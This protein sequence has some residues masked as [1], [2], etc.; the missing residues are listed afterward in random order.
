MVKRKV[1]LL[2]RRRILPVALSLGWELVGR[3]KLWCF[4]E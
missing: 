2:E 4:C 3:T 1:V